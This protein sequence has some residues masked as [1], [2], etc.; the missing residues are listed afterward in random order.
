M[1]LLIAILSVAG[2]W[3]YE[4]TTEVSTYVAPIKTDTVYVDKVKT[5][6]ITIVKVTKPKTTYI[7]LPDTARR[8]RAEATTIITGVTISPREVS[9]ERIDT[10]GVVSVDTHT[11]P[12]TLDTMLING[13]G[14]A[15]IK[16]AP[17]VK[18]PRK[19]RGLWAAI[20]AGAMLTL[21]FLTR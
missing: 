15:E 9:I 14:E 7:Y 2:C 4:P 11:L 17:N 20:G 8:K 13:Q 3:H 19:N 10:A 21:I 18:P 12:Q 16:A 1:F 6:T 5:D